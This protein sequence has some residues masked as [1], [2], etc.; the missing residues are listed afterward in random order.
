LKPDQ[1]LAEAGMPYADWGGVKLSP[2]SWAILF[3]VLWYFG[4]SN[5]SESYSDAKS[6]AKIA[7][8]VIAQNAETCGSALF[9]G[10]GIFNRLIVKELKARGWYGPRSPAS[11][12][13]S[14]SVYRK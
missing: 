8:G 12:F 10:H 9:V 6:R 5:N 7:A 3:R 13:W 1:R 11:K 4:Y 14:N 2:K